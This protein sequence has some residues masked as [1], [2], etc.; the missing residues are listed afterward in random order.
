MRILYIQNHRSATG[1]LSF[2]VWA[3]VRAMTGE[4]QPQNFLQ[5]HIAFS[6]INTGLDYIPG[7]NWA[8]NAIN[9]R[10]QTNTGAWQYG[11]EGEDPWH[12]SIPTCVPHTSHHRVPSPSCQWTYLWEPTR[13]STALPTHRVACLR[14][15]EY[16]MS[17]SSK[18]VL[19]NNSSNF[20]LSSISDML[21]ILSMRLT[22]C[23]PNSSHYVP[24]YKC[25]RKLH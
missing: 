11:G 5:G 24:V 8:T 21:S 22:W 14:I 23:L 18:F 20:W 1:H 3:A 25:V 9:A 6:F 13:C 7:V 12:K 17:S 15:S 4:L 2:L 16:V 19:P 10:S